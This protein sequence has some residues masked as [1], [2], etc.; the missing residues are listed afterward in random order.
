ML[1]LHG[2]HPLVEVGGVPHEVHLVATLGP[3]KKCV[4]VP[5]SCSAIAPP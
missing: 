3:L 5:M 1:H 4:T 2:G